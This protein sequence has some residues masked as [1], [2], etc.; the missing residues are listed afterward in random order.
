MGGLKFDDALVCHKCDYLESK[1]E[2]RTLVFAADV[3]AM[4]QAATRV[5]DS[6]EILALGKVVDGRVVELHIP[7]QEVSGG[8]C[9][10]REQ[11]GHYDLMI[12][13]HH[14]MG[15]FFSSDD[16]ATALP[17]YRYNVVTSHK[18]DA[19][20]VER[21][22]LPC[23]GMGF[24]KVEVQY[25]TPPEHA[26]LE[27]LVLEKCSIKQAVVV[28]PFTPSPSS[29]SPDSSKGNGHRAP[30]AWLNDHWA[31]DRMY[32][33]SDAVDDIVPGCHRCE[34]YWSTMEPKRCWFCQKELSPVNVEMAMRL[35]EDAEDVT[36]LTDVH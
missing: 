9:E 5:R 2:A 27:A 17:N 3:W 36:Q 10:L 31:D 12:H 33:A 32:P 24:T 13:S 25:E 1:K 34:M 29:P 26:A 4:W 16:K 11:N 22:N 35:W 20:A 18:G 7:A 19:E 28:T 30:D 15:A 21:I 14:S 6:L 23:G 8:A